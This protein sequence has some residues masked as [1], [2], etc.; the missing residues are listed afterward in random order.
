MAASNGSSTIK[1]YPAGGWTRAE[2]KKTRRS[3]V[4]KLR[5]D[6]CA[7]LVRDD[8]AIHV[9]GVAKFPDMAIDQPAQ[10]ANGLPIPSDRIRMTH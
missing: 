5:L 4:G 7:Q 6:G 2:I 1:C 10:H 9:V 8:P 3:G